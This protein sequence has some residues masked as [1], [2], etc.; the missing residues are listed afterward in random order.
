MKPNPVAVTGIG[1]ICPLGLSSPESWV[2]MVDGKS[3][4]RPITRFDA[5][6]CVT[7]IAGQIPDEYFEMERGVLPANVLQHFIL[8]AR[9]SI[10]V[11]REAMLDA[12]MSVESLAGQ[13]IGVISG[14]GGSTYGDQLSFSDS[15]E[16]LP[17][18]PSE[19]LNSLAAAVSLHFSLTGPS[20]NVATACASGAF[21]VGVASD[22][23]RKTGRACIA[24]GADSMIM[25]DTIDGFNRLMALSEFNSEPEKASRP[26]DR[27]RS[28]FVI[29]EGACAVFLE[30]LGAAEERGAKI[31]AVISGCAFNS[32]AYNIVMPEPQGLGMADVMESA[33]RRAGIPKEAVGYISA[34]GTSTIHN[35]LAETQAIKK[36]F[37]EKAYGLAV[38]SQKSMIGHTIGA[39][40]A[41]GFAVAA[42]SLH[43]AILTPTI[44]QEDPDPACDLDYVPNRARPVKHI[45]AALTNSFGFG[46]HNAT[47]VLERYDRDRL[48]LAA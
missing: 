5:T 40:G 27:K 18:F 19:M 12:G 32:E 2:N 25:K 31:Y 33:L 39:A 13:P 36:V 26:F 48:Q 37:G 20:I 46:G 9:L 47:I 10:M 23:V 29:S 16:G 11:V 15:P 41:I 7:K 44:N 34:H 14:C 22:V 8:P 35:D 24:L 3:G 1:M 42:L 4:I 43:H 21:A 45:S 28:G 30:P 17:A 38:S 6:D